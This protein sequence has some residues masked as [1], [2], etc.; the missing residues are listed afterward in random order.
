MSVLFVVEQFQDDRTA[1]R[2]AEMMA[3]DGHKIHFL[4]TRKG[5]HHAIDL[6]FIKS[7]DYAEG[8]HCLKFDCE[9]EG[10]LNKIVDGIMLIDCNGWVGLIEACDKIFSWV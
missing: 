3:R 6:E 10:L 1:F 8:V 9:V 2:A 4:F 7:L 5:C